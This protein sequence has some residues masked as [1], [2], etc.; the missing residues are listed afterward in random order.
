M[1]A[2]PQRA[3][4]VFKTEPFKHQLHAFLRSRDE[5]DFALLMEMGTGKTKVA[6][7]TAAWLY[8]RGKIRLL[9]VIAPNGVHRNWVDREIPAHMPE[10]CNPLTLAWSSSLDTTKKGRALIDSVCWGADHAGL[11]VVAFNVEAFQQ[12]KGK[13]RMLLERMLTAMP[14]MLVLD[15]S[16]RIKTP[17]ATRTKTLCTLSKKA[18]YRRIL[19]GTPVT[20]SP[21]DL[22]SQFKFLGDGYLGF[23]N[24][25]SFKHHYAEWS[26]EHNWKAG[27]DYEKLVG[28]RNLPELTQ[29]VEALS[30]RVLKRDCLDLPPKL[31]QQRSVEMTD[32]QEALYERLRKQTLLEVE[33]GSIT[34]QNV[35]TRMLRLQQVLGG[36][37]TTDD[38]KDVSIFERHRDNPRIMALLDYVEEC[39]GKA[40]VWA[41]F[42]PEIKALAASLRAVYG[43]DSVVEYWGDISKEDRERAVNSFQD[44][45][46]VRFFVGNQTTGGIGLTL[47]AAE[48]MHYYSNNFSYEVR[49][50]SE[51]RPHRSGLTHAVTYVDYTT[52]GTLDEHITTALLRKYDVAR[53]I[54]R[55]EVRDWLAKPPGRQ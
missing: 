52:P 35:L 10:W 38:G 23:D 50:Q 55:D 13:A 45:H 21:L 7:D 2:T 41:R 20:N 12:L 36:F 25:Y 17:G 15:E 11:R 5:L 39:S 8:L 24:F 3:D 46:T 53:Q 54:T 1:S 27:K 51:D 33:Q 4:Y 14:A 19:T 26:K 34:M 48:Y 9:V 16:S 43:P 28:Y 40:I 29:R 37:I 47:T 31:Y 42:I 18:R 49:T 44:D 32:Q 22:Y 30:Y 6:I